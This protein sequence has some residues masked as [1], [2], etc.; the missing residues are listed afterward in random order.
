M[1]VIIP[2]LSLAQCGFCT[3]GIPATVVTQ[4][5]A[6]GPSNSSAASVNFNK[7]YDPT[8]T[9]ALSCY[10]FWDTIT[11]VSVSSARN[12][13]PDST[14]YTFKTDVNYTIK[15]PVGGGLSISEDS[16]ITYGPDS[17]AALGSPGDSVVNGPDT[18]FNKKTSKALDK[19]GVTP[20]T[21]SAGTIPITITFG[22]G[23]TATGGSNYTYNIKTNFVGVFK[24]TYYICPSVAL[25]TSIQ[26]F[27]ATQNGNSI[28]LQWLT[29]NEQN[30]SIYEIQISTDGKQ[31]NNA[32]E[33]HGD[34]ATE[35]TSTKYQY[36]YNIDQA[37]PGTVYFRV[38]RIDASGRVSYSA[39]LIVRQGGAGDDQMSYQTYPN[40]ATNSL[41]FRFNTAQTGRYHLELVNTAGQIVQQRAVTLTGGTELR[42]D[43]NPKPVKGLYFLRTT[44]LSHDQHYVSKVF[45]N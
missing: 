42:L 37:N 16:V 3:G 34:P 29:E 6:V 7:Y 32:G 10:S 31:F 28:L 40:P 14:I 23:A 41:V 19:F 18:F 20:Y 27:T 11:A 43:L 25:A 33:A 2:R 9:T 5:I 22:G 8:G 38:K 17:L 21:G 26:N 36:Q 39:I 15:G 24:L 1:M 45:I 35:G 4:T 12:E 13:D 30:N 44:D